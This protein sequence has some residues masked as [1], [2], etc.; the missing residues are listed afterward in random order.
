MTERLP[1]L[2]EPLGPEER[3]LAARLARL[4][5]HGEPSPALDARILAAARDGLPATGGP[6]RKTTRWPWA[7]GIAASVAL[8]V[9]A[10][11]VPAPSAGSGVAVGVGIG[12]AVGVAGASLRGGLVFTLAGGRWTCLL[13]SSGVGKSSLLRLIAGLLAPE[14]GAGACSDRRPL[15]GR[16]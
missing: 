7:F 6:V 14:E 16:R 2:P 11:A 3:A 10:A 15:A 9:A 13:G 12:V 1:P 5:P 4:G 8:A